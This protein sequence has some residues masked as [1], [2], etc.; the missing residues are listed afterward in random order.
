MIQ[1]GA[2]AGEACSTGD[3]GSDPMASRLR[4]SACDAH[5][6]RYLFD[7]EDDTHCEWR[8]PADV[9]MSPQE[10]FPLFCSSSPSIFAYETQP[11]IL[12]S[13]GV[14]RTSPI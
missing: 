9:V 1:S 13:I 4:G 11:D 14:G 10:G 6:G 2:P 3:R 5:Y 7:T 12:P 8:P